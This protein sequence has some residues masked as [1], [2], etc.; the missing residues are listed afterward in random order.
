LKKLHDNV[1]TSIQNTIQQSNQGL[2][3]ELTKQLQLIAEVSGSVN[4][5]LK[6]PVEP[7]PEIRVLKQLYFSSIYS[8]EDGIQRAETGTFEWMFEGDSTDTCSV[9]ESEET[10]E[11][12]SEEDADDP[13]SEIGRKET[14]DAESTTSEFEALVKRAKEKRRQSRTA[15]INWLRKE[16][17]IFHI[18]G[19]AGSGKSTLMK[20]LLDHPQTRIELKQWAADKQLV[21]AHFFFWRSGDTIQKSLTGLYRSILFETL[22]ACPDLVPEVFP[23]QYHSFSNQ[24][25]QSSF[26]ELYFRPDALKSGMERLTSS[27]MFPGHRFCFF[28][29]GLDEYEG[30]EAD[31]L[32]H[33]KLA[34]DLESW[35]INEDIKILVS[36]RP[37]RE[38]QQ[39][40]SDQRRIRL[41][42][43]T[44]PDIYSLGVNMFRRDKKFSSVQHCY[45][46]L[47]KKVVRYSEGVF[48]W[49]RLALQ[50][51]LMATRR[52]VDIDYLDKQLDG[53]PKD[54][55]ELYETILA[56][57]NPVDRVKGFKMLLLVSQ[58]RQV[59]AIDLTWIDDLADPSFPTSYKMEAY[60]DDEMRRR[61]DI[62]AAEIEDI[63]KG[64]LEITSDFN[65][66]LDF[67][68][69]V[70]FSHRTVR[71]FVR[72]S[73]HLREA[74]TKFPEFGHDVSIRLLLAELWF[75]NPDYAFNKD[76]QLPVLLQIAF[77]GYPPG[78]PRHAYLDSLERSITYH[79]GVGREVLGGG[80]SYYT[81]PGWST[82]A[83][84]VG[85]FLHWVLWLL[86]DAEYVRV[87]V[88]ADP[89]LLHAQDELSLIVS[90]F[91][92]SHEG[93]TLKLLFSLGASPNEQVTWED[94]SVKSTA[95][96]IFCFYFAT[97][98]MYLDSRRHVSIECK[99]LEV[100]LE[101]KR[102]DTNCQ[103]L[104]S[105]RGDSY[106]PKE[107]TH[108]ISLREIVQ[109]LKPDNESALIKLMD[110][111]DKR[112]LNPLWR[113]MW[114]SEPKKSGSQLKYLPFDL[115]M[116]RR[117]PSEARS[118]FNH[119]QYIVH[120]LKWGGTELMVEKP[121]V[122]IW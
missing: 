53:I 49:A 33:E 77:R 103:I 35:A 73:S 38:F 92:T 110:R 47:V 37:H 7:S 46:S 96:M 111:Q 41:H 120:S 97:L 1:L 59:N 50:S 104:I 64:L 90:G 43:L 69:A 54:I 107:P 122:R 3:L 106:I 18:S 116:Q 117:L 8:R 89:H 51:M 36:S 14:E 2:S 81:L 70:Q 75:I 83:D 20:F 16:N 4:S 23:S 11:H 60:T 26:D 102:V 10:E 93:N 28:I 74:S 95:W 63:T 12:L 39:T 114:P 88:S 98:V 22:K 6:M 24:S 67:C 27:S 80:I 52:C 29:D 9:S 115:D 17:N 87:R 55:N 101:T 100:F 109:Q 5:L 30:N 61:L 19:K 62:V 94:K 108:V 48:L 34:E 13:D 15:F 118:L 85:S 72:Q 79:R 25:Q 56:S 82:T 71:D 91:S 57:I 86:D 105:D 21:F 65:D 45:K 84:K 42:E 76:R 99:K 31:S 121:V 32:E 66:H 44:K 68:K 78:K 58:M 40:F 113:Y 112:G 119:S